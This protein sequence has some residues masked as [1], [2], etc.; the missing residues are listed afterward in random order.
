MNATLLKGLVALVPASALFSDSVVLFFRRKTVGSL[1]QFLGAGC[2]L[3][4]VLAHLC[5]GLHPFPWMQWGHENSVGHY[6]DLSSAVLG[7]TLFPLG[8]LL[9]ALA[10]RA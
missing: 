10:P 5:E 8:Y 3:V 6:L 2:L 1:L 4:V 7:L 9:H